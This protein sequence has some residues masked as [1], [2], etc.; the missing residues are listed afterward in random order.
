MATPGNPYPNISHMPPATGGVAVAPKVDYVL[1]EVAAMRDKW[2]LIGDCLAGQDAVKKKT[3]KYLPKPNAEDESDA[4]RLR[5]LAYVARAVF[6]NVTANTVSGLVGQVFNSDPVSEYPPELEPMWYDADG[7]GVTLIQLAKKVMTS[8]LSLGRCGLLVDFPTGPK[9]EEG[10]ARPYSRQE[11]MDGI[12]RPTIQYYGATNIINWRYEMRGAVSVL[13]LVVLTEDYIIKDDGFEIERGQECRVL[14]LRNGIYEVEIWRRTDEKQE[15]PYKLINTLTPTDGSGKPFGYIPFY[16]I[17]AQNNDAQVDKPPM[18]DMACSNIAHYRNSAD[19]EDSVFMVGQPTPY[20]SGLTQDW[21]DKVLKGTVQLG[22][23]G[24]V[25]LPPNG[26][27]GLVQA[28]EN[29]MVKEAMDQKQQQMVAIGA[30]LVETKQVQRTLGEAK[31]ENTVVVSTLTSCARNVSQGIENA[32]I[33]AAAFA[34]AT[35]DADS[36]IFQLSTDFAIQKMSPD[37]RRQ[38]L[39]EWQGGI[40][41]FTEARAQLRQSGVATLDDEEARK[42]IEGDQE[43]TVNLDDPDNPDDPA[44][45]ANADDPPQE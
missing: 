35:V 31:M 30:Q 9:D 27:M 42:E 6:Y 3:I 34:N 37:E 4:N 23:R 5:Y 12:A 43:N 33:A 20:F 8:T 15:G 21:V 1:P 17:G 7:K 16:F 22:S 28:T 19:Y 41:S 2:E 45:P 11:V 10:N 32:L 39:A 13:S 40:L 26:T 38:L 29:T 36:I 25:P 24:A 18:Y 14:R 44:N